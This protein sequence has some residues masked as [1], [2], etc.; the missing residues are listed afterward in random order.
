MTCRLLQFVCPY[1]YSADSALNSR[2]GLAKKCRHMSMDLKRF[3]ET[4]QR[5]RKE[6]GLS[7]ERLVIALDTLAQAGPTTDYRVIDGTL[8]SRWEQAREQKG[9]Q[10][11]PTRPYVLYL[12]RLFHGHLNSDRAQAWAIHAGYKLTPQELQE[13][14]PLV[15][16]RQ[17]GNNEPAVSPAALPTVNNSTARSQAVSGTHHKISAS[18]ECAKPILELSEMPVTAHFHG[19][20]VEVTALAQWLQQK[21]EGARIRLVAVLGMGGIGKTALAAHLVTRFTSPFANEFRFVLWRSVLNAPPLTEV[22]R[23]WLSLLSHQTQHTLPATQEEQIQLL[24][25]YLH[26]ERCLLV[27][28]NLESILQVGEQSGQLRP[29]YEGY[30]LLL[31]GVGGSDH[32]SCLLLTSREQPEV[33]D[34]LLRNT[35]TARVLPLRGLDPQAGEALLH[36]QGLT[37]LPHQ[38]TTLVQ[39]YSGNPLALQIVASTI[40]DWFAGDLAAF[41][42]EGT[43]VFHDIRAVL[44][45]QVARLSELERELVVWLAIEREAVTAPILRDNL[46]QKWPAHSFL[47]ALHALTRRSL[48]LKQGEGYTL[49]NVVIEYTTDR[50]IEAICTELQAD[51]EVTGSKD[52][53]QTETSPTTAHAWFNRFALLKAQAKE[54]VRQSQ[55]R[56]IIQPIVERMLAHWGRHAFV[57]QLQQLLARLRAAHEQQAAPI[58]G[59]AGGNLLNLLLYVN[60][61]LVGYDFSRLALWQAYL[62][63][64][65]LPRVHLGGA[66]LRGSVFTK[67]F[68]LCRALAFAPDGAVLAGGMTNG[69]I[70]LW[71]PDDGQPLAMIKVHETR[72]WDIAFSPDGQ[73]LASGSK[74]QTVRL[75]DR[76]TGQCLRVFT[77]HTDW[78]RTVAFHPDGQIVASGSQDQTVRLWDVQSGDPLH[79]LP[80]TGWVLDLAFSPDGAYLASVGTDQ[81]LCLW[82]VAT[83]EK[84]GAWREHS[85]AIYT[86]TFSP[87][88]ALLATGSDDRTL[89]LWE[90]AAMRR[91]AASPCRTVLT[92][93]QA[94]IYVTVFSSDSTRLFSGGA[95]PVIR[96]WDVTTGEPLHTLTG[97]QREVNTL[98]LSPTGQVLATGEADTSIVYLWD[99]TPQP[100]ARYVRLGYR[101]WINAIAFHPE[102]PLLAGARADGHIDLWQAA[103]GHYRQSLRGVKSM[104]R[105][106]AFGDIPNGTDVHLAVGSTDG[107]VRL[108]T[109]DAAAMTAAQPMTSQPMGQP[110]SVLQAQGEIHAVA[111]SQQ[112]ARLFAGSYAGAVHCWEVATGQHLETFHVPGDPRIKSIAVSPDGQLLAVGSHNATVALWDVASHRLRELQGHTAWIWT[113][114]FHPSGQFLASGS[115]DRTVRLWHLP[116]GDAYETLPH[117]TSLVQVIAFSPDGNRL[118][119]G[120]GDATIYLWATQGLIQTPSTP[121]TLIG[122]LHGHADLIQGL[123]FSHDSALLA[124]ASLD[125]TIKIWETQSQ[126]C[127][128]TLRAPGPYVGMNITGVTGIT[129]AQ[130]EALKALGAITN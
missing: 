2:R 92:G 29:G 22:L 130:Q 107:T 128:H 74:D 72:I 6:A 120:M 127:L 122:Q 40:A 9:R 93:H 61:D 44:D 71:Q 102:L 42:R 37:L 36:A 17:H 129:A 89:R 41:Q 7:Q 76:S 38:A 116:T 87:D 28:D 69:E 96:I 54:Y 49:Q 98:T 12:I 105:A 86:V 33:L 27:L 75:T 110:A 106:L 97:H 24:L 112:P 25:H 50:L 65:D 111:F 126:R 39:H 91:R 78:V 73:W 68:G 70:H 64:V 15:N 5:L 34:R 1:S 46:V 94:G 48:L 104:S 57:A 11:K 56:L 13:L 115:F 18:S 45:Q 32:N 117:P 31:Q 23:G 66:D 4:L 77:G 81:S 100:R 21:P 123:A 99:L 51:M 80:H 52:V 125:G 58:P 59:Y 95:E 83:G 79:T 84:V 101:H 26:Q 108:W 113:V 19:R 63:G 55:E 124:S 114:A 20:T 30:E 109:V 43:P 47:E 67:N 90:V 82:Q 16:A 85:A 62:Q 10:W 8:I 121:P 3:G 14:F 103:T 88:G 118:A 119:V 53:I 60:V 35:A